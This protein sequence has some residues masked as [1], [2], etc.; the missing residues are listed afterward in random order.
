MHSG[1]FGV[2]ME[3]TYLWLK[4][5]VRE[6]LDLLIMIVAS[7]EAV[8]GYLTTFSVM[9]PHDFMSLSMKL[10]NVYVPNV[11]DFCFLVHSAVTIHIT[12]PS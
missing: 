6:P 5:M 4:K 9:I 3:G 12:L 2:L 10:S 1:R 7:A 8:S 11:S